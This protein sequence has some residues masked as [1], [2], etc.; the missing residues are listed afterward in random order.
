MQEA[1]KE[2]E[3]KFTRSFESGPVSFRV[4]LSDSAVTIAERVK[5]LL[6]TRAQKG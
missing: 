4:S 1:E 2:T 5:M 6:E 3:F